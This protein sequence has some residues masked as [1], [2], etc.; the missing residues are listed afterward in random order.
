[1]ALKQKNNLCD[2][3]GFVFYACSGFRFWDM[4][5]PFSISAQRE[6]LIYTRI[7]KNKRNT[8]LHFDSIHCDT[9]NKSTTR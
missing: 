4:Q 8:S 3:M 1:M 2:S 9:L 5:S 6:F 7:Q